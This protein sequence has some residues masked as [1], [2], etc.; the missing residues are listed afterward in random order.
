VNDAHIDSVRQEIQNH[1]LINMP[2]VNRLYRDLV[3]HIVEQVHYVPLPSV[4]TYSLW[5][6]WIKNYYGETPWRL[7]MYL[8][9]DQDLKVEI[10]ESEKGQ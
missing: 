3:P 4:Y 8:W 5:W 6:P 2:E 7:F 1:A 10:L 9:I